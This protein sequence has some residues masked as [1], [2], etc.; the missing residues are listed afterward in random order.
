VAGYYTVSLLPIVSLLLYRVR[1]SSVDLIAPKSTFDSKL[2]DFA[3][4]LFSLGAAFAISPIVIPILRLSDG[5]M[6]LGPFSRIVT[7]TPYLSSLSL[8]IGISVYIVALY[9]SEISCPVIQARR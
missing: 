7:M 1:S 5:L 2:V 6:I 4:V 9:R 3:R 8:L